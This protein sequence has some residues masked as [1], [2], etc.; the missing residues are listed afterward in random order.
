MA[1]FDAVEAVS[2]VP[3]VPEQQFAG[4]GN[5]FLQPLRITDFVLMAFD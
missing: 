5:I 3:Q 4:K 1:V 2:A